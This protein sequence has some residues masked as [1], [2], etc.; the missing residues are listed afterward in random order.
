[1]AID[2]TA[3]VGAAMKALDGYKQALENAAE[4]AVKAKRILK[5]ID[6]FEVTLLMI[7]S[8]GDQSTVKKMIAKE[9]GEASEEDDKGGPSKSS[10]RD[11]QNSKL[12]IKDMIKAGGNYVVEEYGEQAWKKIKENILDSPAGKLANFRHAR[13]FLVLLFAYSREQVGHLAS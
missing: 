4:V 12:V 8:R 11:A 5:V 6:L 9:G 1:M 13:Y 10:G 3:M 7:P 2:P